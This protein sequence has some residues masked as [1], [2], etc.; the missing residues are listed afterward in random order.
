MR[1]SLILSKVLKRKENLGL[2][3]DDESFDKKGR[4]IRNGHNKRF[5]RYTTVPVTWETSMT[6]SGGSLRCNRYWKGLLLFQSL[7]Q[8]SNGLRQTGSCPIVSLNLSYS[9]GTSISFLRRL[10]RTH[11]LYFFHE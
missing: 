10:R 8:V 6:Q 9:T 5:L 11:T 4:Q 1:T 2:K 3:E 7:L